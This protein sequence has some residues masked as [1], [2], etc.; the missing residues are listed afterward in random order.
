MVAPPHGVHGLIRRKEYP[1]ESTEKLPGRLR[2][3]KNN[4]EFLTNMGRE[5]G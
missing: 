1:G 4:G 2:R 5:A 3:S